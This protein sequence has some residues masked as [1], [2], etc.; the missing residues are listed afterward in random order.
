VVVV[1]DPDMLRNDVLA[2]CSWGAD[3][4]A[5][6]MLEWLRAGGSQP[7][8]T[9]VFDEYHQ[10]FGH[11]ESLLHV[12]WSFLAGHPVGRALLALI[13][14]ALVWLLANGPRAIPPHDREVVERRDPLEQVDACCACCASASRVPVRCTAPARMMPFLRTPPSPRLIGPTT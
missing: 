9:L 4:I 11:R 7:R 6:Q 10:G 2:R 14:A 12:V 1:A 8:A 3:V 13:A 5:M